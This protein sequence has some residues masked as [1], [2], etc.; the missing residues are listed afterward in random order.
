MR[1]LLSTIGSR[2]DVQPL[3][4][5]GLK[6]K[7]H[8]ASVRICA[9]PDFAD[10]VKSF[11]F[12][13]TPVG[14]SVRSTAKAPARTAPPTP[15][16]M[17]AIAKTTVASQ[18]QALSD[19]AKGYDVL[20]GANALQIALRTVAEQQGSRYIFVSYSPV[21]LPSP[22][23]SPPSWR[24]D[25]PGTNADDN[26]KLWA[27]D[28]QRWNASWGAALNERRCALGLAPVDD[29]R[30]HIFTARPWLAADATLGPWHDAD[31]AFQTGVWILPDE[32]PLSPELER[33][34]DA[35]DPPVY[36]GFGSVRAPEAIT[37][38]MIAAARSLGRRVIVLK[39]WADLSAPDASDVLAIDEV[40]Q[41]ALF[42]RVA[43]VAHHGGAGTTTA[44]AMSAAPQLIMPQH[45][46][47]PYWA[48]RAEELGVGVALSGSPTTQDL[49]PAF[50]KA[51]APPTNA[52]AQLLS[53]MVR[54]DG[55]ERAAKAILV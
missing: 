35:G 1:V 9:P 15:E 13:F 4:G 27:A 26:T 38:K 7:V 31:T 52:A 16:E 43:V 28:A 25:A 50:E 53:G 51:L 54:R 41:Q 55:A 8:G 36:V 33:F 19:A 17:L 37:D 24:G 2:G 30:S 40:N 45:Y 29:V 47:Q 10:W 32:R 21:T 48:E 22:R 23:H 34:L 46:D 44:A 11:G 39:G 3:V 49:T 12:D 6:L 5:L 18:F 42:R 20:V 14:V